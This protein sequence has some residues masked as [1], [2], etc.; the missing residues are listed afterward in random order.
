MYLLRKQILFG[1]YSKTIRDES[2][3]CLPDPVSFHSYL[4]LCF[5]FQHLTDWARVQ[6]IHSQQRRKLPYS[7]CGAIKKH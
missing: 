5:H 7:G 4:D 1:R 2:L 3:K 6:G